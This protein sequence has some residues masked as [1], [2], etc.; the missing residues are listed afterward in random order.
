[1]EWQ[2]LGRFDEP[3]EVCTADFNET[4]TLKDLPEK[5]ALWLFESNWPELH[6]T[7]ER[8]DIVVEFVEH[9]YTKYWWHKYHAHVFCEAIVRAVRRL[10]DEGI[11]F[12]EGNL[13]DKD[14]VH[15]FVR[16]KMRV[17]ITVSGSQILLAAKDAFDAVWERTNRMVEDSRTPY[18][19]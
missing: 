1:M 6:L 12:E 10:R 11:P 2:E 18:C 9:I 13:D 17:P 14:D 16:W 19:F 15:L 5:V 7:R 4:Q 3:I 8:G